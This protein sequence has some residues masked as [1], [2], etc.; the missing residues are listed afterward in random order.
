VNVRAAKSWRDPTG[1]FMHKTRVL[2]IMG[3][4]LLAMTIAASAQANRKPGLYAVTTTTSMGGMQ[5]PQN[6]QLPAGVQMPQGMGS[7]FGPM[8]I[9]VCVTQAMIDKYGGAPPAQPNRNSDCKTTNISLTSNGMTATMVCTG[10]MNATGTI[11]S[12][13]TDANTTSTKMHI[14]GTVQHGANSM[15]IDMS[16]QMTSVYKGPDCGDVKPMPMPSN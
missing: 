5:M 1:E 16:T 2:I 11:E 9:Q 3:C 14:M 15:P 6:V 13:Y 8:T 4:C 7:A 12:T 10:Q